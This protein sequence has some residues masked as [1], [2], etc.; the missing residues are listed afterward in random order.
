MS[1]SL[2]LLSRRKM[3]VVINGVIERNRVVLSASRMLSEILQFLC[4]KSAPQVV[5]PVAF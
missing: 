3:Y 2:T 5:S 4:R 1:K